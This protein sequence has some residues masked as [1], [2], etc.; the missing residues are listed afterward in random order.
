MTQP[1][2]GIALAVLL[3]VLARVATAADTL[4]TTARQPVARGAEW[5]GAECLAIAAAVS[6]F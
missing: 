6:A 2:A 3:L 1:T 4:T 5:P